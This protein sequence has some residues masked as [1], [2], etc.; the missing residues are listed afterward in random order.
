MYEVFECLRCLNVF[1]MNDEERIK[2]C[3]SGK[4]PIS[5]P[6]CG[7]WGLDRITCVDASKIIANVQNV[8]Y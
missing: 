8:V 2:Y 7:C 5:C 1:S 3:K 4:G 6:E